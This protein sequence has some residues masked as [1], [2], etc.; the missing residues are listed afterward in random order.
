MTA[1]T[2][3]GIKA[4]LEQYQINPK[5]GLGQHFLADPNVIDRIVRM[6]GVTADDRILEVGP[7]T[8]TLTRA[9]AGTGAEVVAIEIDERL[10][11]ILDVQLSGLNARIVYGDAMAVNYRELVQP[12]P[13]KV[14]ANLP[15]NVGTPLLLDWL[16]FVPAITEFTVMVQEEV[17]DRLAA[18]R[19]SSAYGLP[20]VVVGLHADVRVAFKVGPQVFYPAPRVDSVVVKLQRTQAASHSERAIELAAAGF[21]QRRKMLRGSLSS[22]IDRPSAVLEE[23]GIDPRLRAEDLRPEDFLRLAE[24][25]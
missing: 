19:G 2:R 13:W 10:R 8:G 25:A 9:L 5:T 3:S 12:A 18:R 16:R 11:P 4:L 14:V 1:Q 6:A 21:G 17:G 15:Y 23:A 22:K 20:S 7:G 24:L